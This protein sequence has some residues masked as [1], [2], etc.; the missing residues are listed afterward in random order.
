ME[1]RKILDWKKPTNFLQDRAHA[2]IPQTQVGFSSY[3]SRLFLEAH[4]SQEVLINSKFLHV[5]ILQ[6]SINMGCKWS[7]S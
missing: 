1:R 7:G 5:T 4:F 6:M 3:E 2:Y